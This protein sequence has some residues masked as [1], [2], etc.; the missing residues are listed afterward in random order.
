MTTN[1]KVVRNGFKMTELGA[2]P[3]EWEVNKV[4]NIAAVTKLAGFEFTEYMEYV[5]DG[6]VIALRALNLKNGKLNLNDIKRIKKDVSDQ[7]PRSQLKI[8][9]LLF[10][11]VGTIGEMAIV[12]ENDKYH[13]APNV[14]KITCTA[15]KVKPEYLLNYLLS[16]YGKREINK[17]LT[18]TSQPALS[19]GNIRELIVAIPP[20][21]EQQKIVEILSTVDDQIEN[22][23]KLIEKTKELKKGLIQQLLTKG[24]GQT[25]FKKTEIGEIPV[26]WEIKKF[27]DVCTILKGQVSPLDERYKDLPHIGNANIE[28]FTGRLLIYKTAQED[29]QISGK[30]LFGKEHVL[31]GKINPHFSKVAFPKL[32]GLCSADIYPIECKQGLI[33]LYLKFLLLESRFIKYAISCSARTGIP[34]INRDELELFKFIVPPKEEQLKIAEILSSVDD[35]IESYEQEKAKYTEL[36]KGLMQQLLTGKIRVTV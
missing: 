35:Q 24:I 31:Y 11:Y 2:I 19:M 32:N 34:K 8:G 1:T 10:S 12:Q 23:D 28:K 6:E 27:T 26:E 22:T 36:K 15:N 9:D 16:Y 21:R 14:A 25:E 30:F 18:T 5:E 33:P 20:N 3:V 17:Y 7:L 13:L 4:G 29:N